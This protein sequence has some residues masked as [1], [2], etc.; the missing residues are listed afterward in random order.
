MSFKKATYNISLLQR[1]FET[2]ILNTNE[3][4]ANPA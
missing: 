4:T 3:K 1:I 2:K